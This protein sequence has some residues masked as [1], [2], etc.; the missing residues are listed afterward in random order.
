MLTDFLRFFRQFEGLIYL[1]LG[2][3]ALI[4]LWRFLRAWEELRHAAFGLEREGAQERLNRAAG[5]LVLI[6]FLAA[7]E[8]ALVSFVVPAVPEANPLMTPTLNLL[9]APTLTLAPLSPDG[10]IQATAAPS[11]IG[12]GGSPPSIPG[13][14]CVPGSVNLTYPANNDT[15]KD[16]VSIIGS[17]DIDNFGFYKY[18]LARPGEENWLSIQAGTQP[19]VE[20]ELGDWDTTRL[21]PGAYLLRL[22]VTNNQGQSLTPCVIQ[23]NVIP[24]EN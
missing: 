4:P 20:A 24:P 13:E 16:I 23:V 12:Q 21:E 3:A 2:L 9:A 18:E 6:L 14:G 17:A 10:A 19:V 8:F 1:L 22:V 15:V 5:L 7:A 11:S